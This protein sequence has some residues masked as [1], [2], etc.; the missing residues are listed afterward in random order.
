M[1][2]YFEYLEEIEDRKKQGLHPKPIDNAELINEII[3]QIKDDK[4]VHREESLD[5]LIYNTLPGTTSAARVKAEFL[6]GI[7]LEEFIIPE[8]T[9]A[10]AFEQL[11]QMKGGPSV[12]ALIDLVLDDNQLIVKE[13]AQC[14]KSQVFLYEADVSRLEKAFKKSNEVVI[15]IFKSYAKAEFFTHLPE[16][17]E[18]IEVVTY[19]AGIGDISTD[20]LSPGNEAHSRSDRELH[21]KCLISEK[22]QKEIQILQKKHPGKRV[23]LIAEKGTMGVGSS[24]MSGVNN[25][26]LW[27]GKQASPYVPFINIAPIVAGTNGVSPI[28]LTTV[29]VT[30]GIGIDLKNWVKK[31]DHNGDV[32]LDQNGDP[33]L[34]QKYSVD[35]GTVLTI[36][37]KKK[38]LFCN[39]EELVDIAEAL[40]PQKI[41]FIRAGGSY[42][43]VFGK[44]LQTFAA[45]TLGINAL[46][47]FA[48][49]KEISHQGQGLTAVEKIFNKNAVGVVSG[50]VL[51]AGSDVRTEN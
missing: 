12:K 8:I 48:T 15:D 3:D 27:I 23:M 4:N 20:L 14:L 32:I 10:S 35:T 38:K 24:R 36:N 42:S 16:V 5:F 7:I 34:E 44:K 40:T 25:V 2:Q 45:K 33:V 21:G 30:G 18:E 41:E 29:G 37:T 43:I 6:K 19:I 26:A 47:V 49:S 50:K 46:P 13:A 1:S 28:F 31:K 9:P 22:A 51:H 39:E 17:P 11:S